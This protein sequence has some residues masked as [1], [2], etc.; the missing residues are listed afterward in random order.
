MLR[1]RGSLATAFPPPKQSFFGQAVGRFVFP[2]LTGSRSSLTDV[3]ARRRLPEVQPIAIVHLAQPGFL[4]I[5]PSVPP[6]ILRPATGRSIS[7]PR[8]SALI[9]TA[10]V[11]TG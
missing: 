10:I 2:S 1:G 3:A 8:I 11:L 7:L 4:G 6:F 9:Q 5:S